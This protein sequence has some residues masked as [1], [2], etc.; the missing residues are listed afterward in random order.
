[1]FEQFSKSQT[2]TQRIKIPAVG[3]VSVQIQFGQQVFLGS[4]QNCAGH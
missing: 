2:Y 3:L 1:M 4:G